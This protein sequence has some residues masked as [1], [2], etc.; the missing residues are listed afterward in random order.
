MNDGGM[1]AME[2]RFA[3]RDRERQERR[4][5]QYDDVRDARGPLANLMRDCI[6]D[7]DWGR[8]VLLLA[9]RL[10]ELGV[11]IEPPKPRPPQMWERLSELRADRP[12]GQV[13]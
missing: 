3:N 8:A 6:R 10:D 12:Y 13:R 5:A 7:D 11:G 2:A 9:A 4:Q 1:A